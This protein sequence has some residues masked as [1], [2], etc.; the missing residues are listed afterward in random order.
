M[1]SMEAKI[2]TTICYERKMYKNTLWK[3]CKNSVG[4]ENSEVLMGIKI[5]KY[6]DGKMCKNYECLIGKF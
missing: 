3:I 6:S 1:N 4:C 5:Y 2:S